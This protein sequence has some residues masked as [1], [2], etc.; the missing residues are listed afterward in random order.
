MNRHNDEL[1]FHV[2]VSDPTYRSRDNLSVT[3]I[4]KEV[5]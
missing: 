5:L 1:G 4:T 2:I 3:G